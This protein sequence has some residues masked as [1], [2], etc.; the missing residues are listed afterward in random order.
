MRA[1]LKS[2]SQSGG[3]RRNDDKKKF[4]YVV[5]L[6]ETLKYRE[7]HI[8]TCPTIWHLDCVCA[9]EKEKGEDGEI[10]FIKHT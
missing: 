5:K 7:D 1:C 10:F 4:K 8:F 6:N 3:R 9:E 2:P